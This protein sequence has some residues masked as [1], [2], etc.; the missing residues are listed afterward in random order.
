MFRTVDV[1]SKA[2]QEWAREVIDRLGPPDLLLNNAALINQ[3]AP[4]WK[5]PTEEFSNLFLT[6]YRCLFR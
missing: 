2:V 6:K 4:L 3:P 5:V 1:T